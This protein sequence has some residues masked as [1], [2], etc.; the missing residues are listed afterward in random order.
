MTTHLG[1]IRGGMAGTWFLYASNSDPKAARSNFSSLRIVALDSISRFR[2]PPGL[3]LFIP[4]FL[5][6]YRT[7]K[8]QVRV[9]DSKARTWDVHNRS[10][11]R[12]PRSLNK[13]LRTNICSSERKELDDAAAIRSCR[14]GDATAF[15]YRVTTAPPRA[16][17]Q[18]QIDPGLAECSSRDRHRRLC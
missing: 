4:S 5:E 2:R 8:R 12:Q 3:T 6:G 13:L 14:S 10:S 7:H 16:A 18:L 11:K 15:R 17:S 1:H 9:T